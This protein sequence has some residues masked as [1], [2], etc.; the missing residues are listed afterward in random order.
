MP[1]DPPSPNPSQRNYRSPIADPYFWAISAIGIIAEAMAELGEDV[2]G[3]SPQAAGRLQKHDERR[4]SF[5]RW[6]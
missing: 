2:V 4:A 5:R 1:I 3:G 6:L